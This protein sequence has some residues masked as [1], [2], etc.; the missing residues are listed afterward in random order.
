MRRVR[1]TPDTRRILF[2]QALRAFGYGFAAVL[3]GTTL[4][5]RHFSATEA[6]GVLAAVVAGAALTSIALARWGDRLGRRRSY[7]ALFV[8][9]GATGTIFAVSDQLWLL[10]VV[11]LAGALSTD[12]VES[13]PFS[14]LEQAMLATDLA[15][16]ERVR[17]FGIYNAVAS[18]AGALGALATALP[19]LVRDLWSDGP[20]NATWF[21]L[22]VP[23]AG[24]GAIVA[25][26]LS[27]AVEAPA[28]PTRTSG[29]GRSRPAVRRLAALFALDSFGGGFTVQAFVAYWFATRFDA[30]TDTTGA[31]FFGVTVLQG[32]S[33]LLA[34]RLAQRVGLLR[35]MVFTHL[36][37]NAFLALIP[38]APNIELAV[39]AL[40]VRT[41]LSQMD[42]PTRQA[43]VMAL[44]DPSER[45]AAAAYTNTARYVIRPA[46]PALAGAASSIALGAPFVI[47]GVIKGVYDLIL[48]R[49]FSTV[50]L[51][52]DP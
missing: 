6:G 14:S 10:I 17:V 50:P 5:R 36:P 33:F 12:V 11:A 18:A 42:V 2:A 9:L 22:I 20:S 34:S 51:P 15:G 27:S 49:W 48:W 25:G 8:L 1:L 35:V 24:C 44:V 39:G 30:S 38:F 45:T 43:Y 47:A 41:L 26:S 28:T 4:H 21:L 46:G 19:S 37:S 40:A 7:A 13:G 29:L 3:L 52:D 31:I 32:I 23:L 16:A